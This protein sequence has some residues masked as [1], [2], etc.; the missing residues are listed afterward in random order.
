MFFSHRYKRMCNTTK[1]LLPFIFLDARKCI[2][3]RPAIGWSQ[4]PLC[5]S[6]PGHTEPLDDF[7]EGSVFA[8]RVRARLPNG[9]AVSNR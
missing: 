7:Q 8:L 5:A 6:H 2:R 3:C 1:C 4:S 9:H